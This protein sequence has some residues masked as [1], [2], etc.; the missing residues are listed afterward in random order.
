MQINPKRKKP[1][2]KKK[3]KQKGLLRDSQTTRRGM[4]T[5]HLKRDVKDTKDTQ[6]IHSSMKG[7]KID[8]S[9]PQGHS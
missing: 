7:D 6:T 1:S 5:V 3:V 4:K 8:A 9:V 2:V